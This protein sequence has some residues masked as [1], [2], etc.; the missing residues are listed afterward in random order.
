MNRWIHKVQ[1]GVGVKTPPDRLNSRTP[2]GLKWWERAATFRQIDQLVNGQGFEVVRVHD[3][4]ARSCGFFEGT[5]YKKSHKPLNHY[6][7][8]V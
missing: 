4:R 8:W 1:P 7:I 6:H 3:V 5:P 2:N